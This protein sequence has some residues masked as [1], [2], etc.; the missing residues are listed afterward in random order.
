M[1]LTKTEKIWYNGK[2]VDWDKAQTHILTHALHYGSGVF[3]G[4]RC[5]KTDKGPAVFR[6]KEHIK[7]LLDSASLYYMDVPYTQDQLEQAVKDT[8]RANHIDA[9]YVRPIIYRG[10]GEMG[11]NPL[12]APVDVAIAVWPWGAY[13]GEEGLKNGIKVMISSIERFNSNVIPTRA[14]ATGQYI[15]SILAKVQS[16][17]AGYDESILL[18]NRGFVSEGPGENV[19]MVKDGILCTP[20]EHASL[21]MGITR[22]SVIEIAKSLGIDVVECDMDRGMLYTADEVFF[23]GTAA[24]VTPIREIDGH[25]I[26]KPGPITVKI[27]D[28]F[29]QI[30]QGKDKKYEKW[31]AYAK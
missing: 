29:F 28:R 14:K 23:T 13:L 20:P 24:E 19:F 31:L 25:V 7:R 2:L 16:L 30:A 27:Q 1:P 26:G 8:I 18:D 10:Y 15:N 3:E 4:I 21:L 17:K 5:Y 9:C 11:L 22:A 12:N 6:L